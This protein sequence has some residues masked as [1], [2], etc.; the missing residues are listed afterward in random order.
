MPFYVLMPEVAKAM[1]NVYFDSAASPFLYR[2][3]VYADVSALV[4]ANKVLFGSDYPLLSQKR[5]M[6]EIHGVCLSESAKGM[7]L[8]GNAQRLLKL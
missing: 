2:P 1:E 5:V 4:G 7:M 3:Q 8:G 6:D